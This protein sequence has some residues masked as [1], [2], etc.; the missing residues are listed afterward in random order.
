[1]KVARTLA[2]LCSL[3]VLLSFMLWMDHRMK[4]Y[5]VIARMGFVSPFFEDV[6]NVFVD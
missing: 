3:L 2:R 1:M 6:S 4:Y 5:G